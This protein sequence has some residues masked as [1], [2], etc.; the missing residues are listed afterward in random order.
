[1]CRTN[2]FEMS[3]IVFKHGFCAFGDN[4]IYPRVFIYLMYLC[5]WKAGKDVK[6]EISFNKS[7]GLIWCYHK[8]KLIY[9]AA[10]TLDALICFAD[11]S[12][13][14]YIF[15]VLSHQVTHKHTHTFTHTS[16]EQCR[17]LTISIYII[18][19]VCWS[20]IEDKVLPKC[21]LQ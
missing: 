9:K 14:T 10:Y 11:P 18:D 3:L 12:L 15:S 20:G 19:W 5:I 2:P 1:M 16:S 7:K 4:V 21:I 6:L 8:R 13:I 17:F